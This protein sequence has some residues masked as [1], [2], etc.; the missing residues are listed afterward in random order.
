MCKFIDVV[1][2]CKDIVEGGFEYFFFVDGNE[3]KF[4]LGLNV[5]FEMVSLF[6]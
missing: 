3:N 2:F 1:F 6:G 4:V 5:C